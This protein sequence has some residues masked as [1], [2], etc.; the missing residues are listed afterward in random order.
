M[1]YP[2]GVTG[3]AYKPGM[4]VLGNSGDEIELNAYEELRANRIQESIRHNLGAEVD[5]TTLTKIAK[6]VSEEVFYEINPADF[7]PIRT[8]GQ[9]AWDNQILVWRE[10]Y[11]ANDEFEDGII[12][13]G[14]DGRLGTANTG[15]EPSL[16]K[17]HTWAKSVQWNLVEMNQALAAGRFDLIKAKLKSRKKNHDLGFQQSVF[18]GLDGARGKGLLNSDAT[19]VTKVTDQSI[20]PASGLGAITDAA[21]V[22]FVSKI[23]TAY[24]EKTNSTAW[25]T[26]FVIPEADFIKLASPSASNFHIKTKKEVIHTALKEITNNPNFVFTSTAYGNKSRN[27]GYVNDSTGANVYAFYR[28]DEDSLVVDMPVP[29]TVTLESTNNGFIYQNVG[30]SRFTTPHIIR[31]QELMLIE[32]EDD[33]P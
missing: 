11:T 17:V 26:H 3:P 24:R 23:L 31:A 28:Y 32:N 5:V 21:L 10:F 16:I 7:V 15:V 20:V 12:N 33:L 25:P 13:D 22:T 14:G 1:Y 2:N 19:G 6:S 4:R 8:D 29:Y 9:S 27:A 30:Y 18:L